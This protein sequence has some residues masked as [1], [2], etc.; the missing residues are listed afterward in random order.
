MNI[1]ELKQLLSNFEGCEIEY[2][3]AKGGFP[4]A[5]W[6]TYSSFGNTNGGVVVLG[7]KEVERMPVVDDLTED[8]VEKLKRDYWATLN[9]GQKVNCILTFEEDVQTYELEG[10]SSAGPACAYQLV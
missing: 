3:S 1:D 2:K 5:F 6:P 8:E 9:D 7:M 4:K 10:G